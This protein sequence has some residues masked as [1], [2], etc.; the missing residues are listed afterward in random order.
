[1]DKGRIRETPEAVITETDHLTSKIL[2][3]ITGKYVKGGDK[4]RGF[5]DITAASVVEQELID[6]LRDLKP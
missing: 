1:M 6:K 3:K 5:T 4:R 2:K